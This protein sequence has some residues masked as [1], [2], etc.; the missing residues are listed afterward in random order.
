MITLRKAVIQKAFGN[1]DYYNDFKLQ[2]IYITITLHSKG[3]GGGGEGG[4]R[5]GRERERVREREKYIY[6]HNTS[7]KLDVNDLATQY[8]NYRSTHDL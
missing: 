3:G 4:E 7:L 8:L 2:Y 5:E 1:H 6:Y